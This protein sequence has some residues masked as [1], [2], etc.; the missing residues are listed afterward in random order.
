MECTLSYEVLFPLKAR[1]SLAK[2]ESRAS[3]DLF[4][5]EAYPYQPQV[6]EIQHPFLILAFKSVTYVTLA[7]VPTKQQAA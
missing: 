2:L 1:H 3:F 4:S 5:F 6:L 7:N